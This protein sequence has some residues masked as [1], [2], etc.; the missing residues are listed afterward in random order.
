MGPRCDPTLSAA[1]AMAQSRS[2]KRGIR[3]S[4][5]A[6]GSAGSGG[7]TG[8]PATGPAAEGSAGAGGP[9]A[10]TPRSAAA[11][12]ANCRHR[13]AAAAKR[14]GSAAADRLRP[15][16]R[17]PLIELGDRGNHRR[18]GIAGGAVETHLVVGPPAVVTGQPVEACCHRRNVAGVG[19]PVGCLI[20]WGGPVLG[21]PLWPRWRR[22][23]LPWWQ[24]WE[25][26]LLSSVCLGHRERC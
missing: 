12:A 18:R 23:L 26:E 17:G 7:P 13:W 16:S 19:P 5:T 21:H 10:G 20:K 8:A 4:Q 11:A 15:M 2:P 25:V 6:K 22:W 24:G 9:P 1:R 14:A 3:S